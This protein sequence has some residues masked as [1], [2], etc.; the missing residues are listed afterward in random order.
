ML[1]TLR[2]GERLESAVCETSVVVVKP[3]ADPVVLTCGGEPMV[4]AGSACER[5]SIVGGHDLG[6]LVGKRYEVVSLGLE[7]LCIRGGDGSLAVNDDQLSIK[8]PK[9]LPASD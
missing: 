5:K 8:S 1:K 6:T 7:V 2:V 9:P 3:P 4:E